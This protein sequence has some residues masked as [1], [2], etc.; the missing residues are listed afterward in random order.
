[1][2]QI[3]IVYAIAALSLCS[4]ISLHAQEKQQTMRRVNAGTSVAAITT[5]IAPVEDGVYYIRVN[6]TGKYLGVEGVNTNN[7]A[8]VVQWDFAANDNHKFM[9]K[10]TNVAG[11]YTIMAV[12]SNRYINVEGADTRDGARIIQWDYADQDNVKWY[13]VKAADGVVL[14]SKQSGKDMKLAGAANNANNGVPVLLNGNTGGQVFTLLP[15]N[16]VKQ[17]TGG[18]GNNDAVKVQKSDVM[19]RVTSNVNF[20]LPGGTTVTRYFNLPGTTALIRKGGSNQKKV[21]NEAS[22]SSGECVTQTARIDMGPQENLT[23]VSASDYLLWN[24]PGLMYDMLTFYAGDYRTKEKFRFGDQRN[25]IVL[26]T[27]VRNIGS[28][29]TETVQAPTRDNI[30]QA[31]SNLYNRFTSD[32]NKTGSQ[33]FVYYGSALESTDEFFM[34]VGASAKYFGGSIDASMAVGN[35]QEYKS[36]YFEATKELFSID[37]MPTQQGFFNGAV[38]GVDAIGYISQAVYG[39]K[40]IGKIEIKNV[41]NSMEG[42]LKVAY[43][44][45]FAGGSLS[46]ENL[47]KE[48]KA[49]SRVFL[50]VVGGTSN[51]VVTC[52]LNN[53]QSTIEN[54]TRSVTYHTAMPLR[55]QFSTLDGQAVKY[56]DVTN[57]FNYER[58]VPPAIAAAPRKVAVNI[59][60]FRVI[61]SDCDLFGEVWVELWSPRGGD[62]NRFRRSPDNRVFKASEGQVVKKNELYGYKPNR[63]VLY[64]NI[65]PELLEGA[66]VHI[67][68]MLK[69][70]DDFDDDLLEQRGGHKAKVKN[71][72]GGVNSVLTPYWE[73]YRSE[74]K[75]TGA[76]I[77]GYDTEFVDR[78]D[79]V[80]ISFWIK[81]EPM[82][83]I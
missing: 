11:C 68:Y 12:H 30:N 51:S 48:C 82:A 43:D 25:P 26:T 17:T 16:A 23:P 63:E 35:K 45:G 70:Q 18:A 27:S 77:Q 58:C 54:I 65:P 76:D 78:G 9:L 74:I 36:M 60:G 75:L 53:I 6:Q 46:I 62:M 20:R 72:T 52:T 33:S 38:E 59:D 42:K 66:E 7:G 21:L 49:E 83:P 13:V 3:K 14:R 8:A 44:A 15:V 50:Y 19:K 22:G 71:P 5:T 41:S 34:K 80:K 47:S 31:I 28:S 55:V 67:Y 64:D 1:M 73:F 81:N 2:K 69:D 4:A 61:G 24:A 39:V 10:R 29:I 56:A 37:A 32:P 57:N 79:G 40:V